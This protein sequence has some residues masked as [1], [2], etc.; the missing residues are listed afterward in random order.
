L[1]D[2]LAAL[3]GRPEARNLINIYAALEGKTPEQ[4]ITEVAGQQFGQ[5]KPA[6]AD[7]AVAHLSPIT[8]EMTR[9]MADVAEIDRILGQGANRAAEIAEPILQQTY[10]IVGMVRS[11]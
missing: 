10:D 8:Q 2:N 1:P 9:L 7:L 6:L 11:R 3:N 4:V 5:F